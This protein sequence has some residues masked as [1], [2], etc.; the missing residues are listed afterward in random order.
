[1]ATNVIVMFGM[2]LA[3]GF[4]QQISFNKNIATVQSTALTTT[5]WTQ[6]TMGIALGA[7]IEVT[8]NTADPCLSSVSTILQSSY[9]IGYYLTEYL[10]T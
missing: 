2:L 10:V 8:A 9:L 5:D 1:M 7:T 4:T 3:A 6:F